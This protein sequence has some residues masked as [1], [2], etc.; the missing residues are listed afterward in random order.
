MIIEL[1]AL[2]TFALITYSLA[3]RSNTRSLIA[4][5]ISGLF[6]G[7]EVSILTSPVAGGVVFFLFSGMLIAISYITLMLAPK[8]RM[9]S[10]LYLPWI[11]VSATIALSLAVTI[12]L[13]TPIPTNIGGVP[14]LRISSEDYLSLVLLGVTASIGIF[15]IFHGEQK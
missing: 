5:F 10:P 4:L 3:T 14:K 2:S 6:V 12:F 15:Y 7:V 13:K 9:R 11:L 8:T 1:I